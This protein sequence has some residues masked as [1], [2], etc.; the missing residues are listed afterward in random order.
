VVITGGAPPVPPPVPAEPA[1]A[2]AALHVHN[3]N[4][5]PVALQTL[6]D[7][8][9]SAQTQGAATPGAHSAPPVS[10]PVGPTAHAQTTSQKTPGPHNHRLASLTRHPNPVALP[11]RNSRT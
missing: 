9:P 8:A 3:P 7:A 5:D 4:A 1:G 2:G 6:L 10:S 11:L